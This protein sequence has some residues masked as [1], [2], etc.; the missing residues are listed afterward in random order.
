MA[1]DAG[2]RGDVGWRGGGPRR[3]ARRGGGRGGRGCSRRRAR[4]RRWDGGWRAAAAGWAARRARGGDPLQRRRARRGAGTV[5]AGH[6]APVLGCWPGRGRGVAARFCA[7]LRRQ[8]RRR[9]W[10]CPRLASARMTTCYLCS[11]RGLVNFAECLPQVVLHYRGPPG[12]RQSGGTDCKVALRGE[13]PQE[14]RGV[15]GRASRP[16]SHQFKE[17][18]LGGNGAAARRR[19]AAARSRGLGAVGVRHGPAPRRRGL[20]RARARP[21]PAAEGASRR[22]HV[23]RHRARC[24]RRC[25]AAAARVPRER[26]D[27]RVGARPRAPVGAVG[28]DGR[29]VQQQQRLDA[30]SGRGGAVARGPAVRVPAPPPRLV[31]PHKRPTTAPAQ[32]FAP[33]SRTRRAPA[34]TAARPPPRRR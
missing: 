14:P 32:P 30:L 23:P 6:R 13:S 18:A 11:Q 17:D 24:H 29:A 2:A 22:R 26:E 10:R 28:G 25:R 3:G 33:Q 9:R 16:A 4:R 7:L 31:R 27:R 8:R 34:A 5:H 19:S 12:P 21:R 1:A 15:R 20:L